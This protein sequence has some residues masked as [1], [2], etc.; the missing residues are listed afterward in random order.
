MVGRTQVGRAGALCAALV[1]VA[2]PGALAGTASATTL[3]MQENKA[4]AKVI[5]PATVHGSTCKSGYEAIELP[6]ANELEILKHASYTPSGVDSKPTVVFSGVNVQVESG[7]GSES[8]AVNGEG[9]LIVGYDE[10]PE[11]Q[12]GSDNLVLGT[13]FQEYTSWGG[14]IA[15]DENH[16]TA[17]VVSISGGDYSTASEFAASV[18]GGADNTASGEASSV[19]GGEGNKASGGVS[20]VGGGF[21]NTASGPW[22]TENGG[23]EDNASGA[24]ASALGGDL[25]VVSGEWATVSGGEYNLAEGP[26]S[27]VA[28]GCDSVTGTGGFPAPSSS[29]AHSAGEAILG[30]L[31]NRATGQSATVSGGA[32]NSATGTTSAVGGGESQTASSKSEFKQ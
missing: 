20:A 3:C 14:F 9:N 15:G 29:C 1:A 11:A 10:V 22:A 5:G 6:S 31:E 4:N 32:K 26:F 18:S 25:N 23:E 28:G 27:D 30:G 2:L 24:Y 19:S 12:T 13:T 17:P 7:A 16:A 8:A 21:K